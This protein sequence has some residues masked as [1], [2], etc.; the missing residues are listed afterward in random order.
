[1]G[2]LSPASQ[3]NWFDIKVILDPTESISDPVALMYAKQYDN[4]DKGR[5]YKFHDTT[6]FAAKWVPIV[7]YNNY[8][9]QAK[10]I[11]YM[12]IFYDDII[13]YMFLVLDDVDDSIQFTTV[14]GYNNVITVIM[15]PHADDKFKAVKL[16]FYIKDIQYIGKT[17]KC[18]CEFNHL[19]L[20]ICHTEQLVFH[21]PSAGCQTDH[22]KGVDDDNDNIVDCP[23]PP[24]KHPNTYELLHVIAE[25]TGLGFAATDH[26][27][28]VRDDKHRFLQKETYKD[29][30]K[31][32][33]AFGGI[34]ETDIFDTWIDLYG[35]ITLVNVSWVMSQNVQ[36]ENIGGYIEYGTYNTNPE[37]ADNYTSHMTIR[38]I[39]NMKMKF[40]NNTYVESYENMVNNKS[41]IDDGSSSTFFDLSPLGVG[42]NNIE[43][44]SIRT[45]ENSLDGKAHPE[46]YL[47]ETQDYRGAEMGT[48]ADSNHPTNHQE[49]INSKYLSRLRSKRIRVRLAYP[50]YGLTRGSLINFLWWEYDSMHKNT[51]MKQYK[52]AYAADTSDQSGVDKDILFDMSLDNDTPLPNIFVSG[53]YYIDA[54][55]FTFEN[56]G[57]GI[58][59]DLYLI[60]KDGPKPTDMLANIYN[61]TTKFKL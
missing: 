6:K 31:K 34:G 7:M 10:Y 29:A 55:T 43:T 53:I 13:P 49:N 17:I 57:S 21:W 41:I 11:T 2:K 22:S 4:Y 59:Q 26:C 51:L 16:N 8:T 12:K 9:L 48:D 27:A 28:G 3:L 42:S 58:K 60:K 61:H 20:D 33:V 44:Q 30:I 35:Y 39:S 32:H 23:L 14:P 50:N 24:N 36:P 1:M 15:A 19:K 37:L 46:K 52:N 40:I 25:N 54:M 5:P 45:I 47:F 56:N 18:R 38:V